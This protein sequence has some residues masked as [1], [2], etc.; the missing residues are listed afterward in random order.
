M[1]KQ[2]PR[3]S[4]AEP[5]REPQQTWPRS[6]RCATC[7]RTTTHVA[8]GCT[9]CM[10]R[11]ENRRQGAL[12]AAIGAPL[13]VLGLAPTWQNLGLTHHVRSGNGWLLL[14]LLGAGLLAK[15]LRALLT[16]SDP[17]A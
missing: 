5:L 8:T 16:G 7:D 1:E 2:L 3:P 6:E 17:E 4:Q 12:F 9:R 10:A 15:G 13:V 11:G 14:A